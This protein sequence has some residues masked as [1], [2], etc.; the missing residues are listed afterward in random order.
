[1]RF[2]PQNVKDYRPPPPPPEGDESGEMSGP[3]SMGSS[4]PTRG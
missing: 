1:M 2:V 4:S 3:A